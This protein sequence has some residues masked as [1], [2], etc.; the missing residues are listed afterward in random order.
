MNERPLKSQF[1]YQS[2]PFE[3]LGVATNEFLRASTPRQCSLDFKGIRIK[4][5]PCLKIF[6]SG[7]SPINHPTGDDYTD[8]RNVISIFGQI[9]IS[10][11]FIF[12][13]YADPHPSCSARAQRSL[14]ASLE[15]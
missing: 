15:V 11:G 6:T 8:I 10:T 2:K 5:F 14:T 9:F 4:L 1:R 3:E 13:L 12:L 7:R